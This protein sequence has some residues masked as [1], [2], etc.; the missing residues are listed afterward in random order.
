MMSLAIHFSTYIPVEIFTI[1]SVWMMHVAVIAVFGAMIFIAKKFKNEI[2]REPG[3]KYVGWFR[4][5]MQLQF[6]NNNKLVFDTIPESLYFLGIVAL[7]YVFINFATCMFGME[8]GGPQIENGQFLLKN[9]D[10]V[11]RALTETE[12]HKM[13]AYELRLFSGH[14]IIFS[15]IPTL[16]FTYVYPSTQLKREQEAESNKR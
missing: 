13:K 8:L 15:Y 2:K 16:F 10:K 3:K 5:N 6:M 7:I 4:K 11:I 1:N 14:W 9:H 12:F